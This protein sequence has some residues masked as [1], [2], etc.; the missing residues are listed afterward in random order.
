MSEVF[1]RADTPLRWRLWKRF[2]LRVC[3]FAYRRLDIPH[4]GEP[5]GIPFRRSPDYPCEGY[6]PRDRLLGDW[7][8]CQGDGHYLCVECAHFEGE[9]D[10][11]AEA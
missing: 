4:R 8:G 1:V 9:D 7:R 6:S 3:R 2:W 10:D 5:D 11:D